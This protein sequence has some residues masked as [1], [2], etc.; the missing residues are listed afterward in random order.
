MSEPHP[1]ERRTSYFEMIDELLKEIDRVV[2]AD[3]ARQ[4]EALG[5][6]TPGQILG[7]LAAWIEHVHGGDPMKPVPWLFC[8]SEGGTRLLD[9][10]GALAETGA[11][12][13]P[14]GRF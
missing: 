11:C 9:V 5:T 6:W 14:C 12:Q 10:S 13:P 8:Y 2:E 1:V 4:I 3:N 7:H